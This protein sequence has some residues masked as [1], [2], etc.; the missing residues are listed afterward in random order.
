MNLQVPSN[1][2]KATISYTSETALYTLVVS[3]LRNI[4]TLRR[5]T[6]YQITQIRFSHKTYIYIYM[7]ISLMK[8][9]F[10]NL[11]TISGHPNLA[12]TVQPTS[13]PSHDTL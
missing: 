12:P 2:E 10:T 9:I 11:N 5:Y 6:K 4:N 8:R 3:I 7:D 13:C 1:A